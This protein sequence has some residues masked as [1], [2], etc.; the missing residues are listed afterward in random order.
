MPRFGCLN[1]L[2]R[3]PM[4]FWSGIARRYGGI[5]RVPLKGRHVYLISDPDLI[6]ELLIPKRTKY[7]KNTRYRAAVETF[8]EGLLLSEGDHWRRQRRISQPTFKADYVKSKADMMA[9]VTADLIDNWRDAAQSGTPIDVHENFLRLTQRVAGTY[10]MGP[11]F[12]RIEPEFYAAAIAIKDNWPLPPRSVAATYLPPPKGRDDRLYAAVGDIGDLIFRFIEAHRSTD[13]KDCGVLEV[14]V[15]DSRAQGDEYDAQS[16]RDQLLTLFFA[17]HE[18][19][20]TSLSWIHY[21]L[22]T[23]PDCRRRVQQEVAEVLGTRDRPGPEDLESLRYTEQVVNES[24]RLYSPIH[25]ISRVAL[26]DDTIGGFDIAE[27]SM[28]YVSL[29]ATHRLPSV[30]PDPD[31]FD[32]G[33]FEPDKIAARPRFAFIPYAAG[34]R[35]CIGSTMATAELKLAVAQIARHY[36]LDVAPGH[37]VVMEA[38]TTM[39][40]KHGMKMILQETTHGEQNDAQ[41]VQAAAL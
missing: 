10:L 22:H 16:L 7:R 28:I 11:D 31:S 24:L 29:Y 39:Y 19:S 36:T 12:D 1:G 25:S 38:G 5:A 32:P 17:G 41:S 18:T 33:R 27:G 35:N 34:H 9:D 37:R 23:H 14:I 40:P 13:F 6:Y 20:A 15:R 21:L 2:L 3:N 8:G 30:W 26:E 4:A